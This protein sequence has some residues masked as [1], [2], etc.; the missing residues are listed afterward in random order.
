M[1]TIVAAAAASHSP[2]ITAFPEMAPADK[3]ENF[4]VGMR[5]IGAAFA[6]AEPDVIITVT[7]EHFANF[8]LNNIPAFCIGTADGYFGPTE[9]FLRVPQ[10]T[11]PGARPLAKQLVATALANDFD[12]SFSEE[13]NLEHGTMVPMHWANEGMKTPII[14]I[15]LNNL[16]PPLLSPKRVY[17]FGQFLAKAIAA[18]DPALRV[19]LLAT[20]GLSHKVGTIDAGEVNEPW[21]HE[22]LDDVVNGRSTKLTG[23]TFEE[24]HSIGNG[25]NEV[26][27]WICVMGAVNDAPAEIAAYEPMPYE[28]WA[29]GCGA[30]IWK[31]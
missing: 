30:L 4:Y 18:L 28:G 12:V 20:G 16:F 6:A 22:F 11:I 31:V 19:A 23:Y 15:M 26:R 13:L 25:T 2:G 21:D 29:T 3:A 1:A 17:Q 9:P 8:Y 10:C 14:P 5:K 24:I 27:N 7:N